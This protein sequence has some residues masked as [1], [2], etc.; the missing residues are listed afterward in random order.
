MANEIDNEG[1]FGMTEDSYFELQWLNR[2]EEAEAREV[3]NAI[4]LN[5]IL[6]EDL[7]AHL[8]CVDANPHGN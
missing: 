1:E 3:A 2:Q 7:E 5:Y 6:E 8:A 4:A